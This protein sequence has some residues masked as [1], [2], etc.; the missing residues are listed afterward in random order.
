MAKKTEE[1]KPNEQAEVKLEINPPD[2][3]KPVKEV[4]LGLS[5]IQDH[6]ERITILEAKLAELE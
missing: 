4:R 5:T 3:V 1:V 2:Y 6:E